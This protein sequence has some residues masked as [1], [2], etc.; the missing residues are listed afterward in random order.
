M[1]DYNFI[2]K[3]PG[4]CLYRLPFQINEIIAVNTTFIKSATSYGHNYIRKETLS[5]NYTIDVVSDHIEGVGF[6][7]NGKTGDI[8]EVTIQCLIN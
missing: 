4:T 5:T 8:I 2:G 7:A 6:D 3:D 1:I